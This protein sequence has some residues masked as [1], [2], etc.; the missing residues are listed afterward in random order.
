MVTRFSCVP[1]TL[2]RTVST[3]VLVAPLASVPSEHSTLPLAGAHVPIDAHALTNS[4]SAGSVSVRR[5]FV[6]AAGPAFD[7]MR[8]KSNG[9]PTTTGLLGAVAVTPTLW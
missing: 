6:A 4:V 8:V 2:G 9:V 5:T 1:P 3:I 7:T